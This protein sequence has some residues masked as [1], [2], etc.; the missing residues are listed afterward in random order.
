MVPNTFSL[1]P[2][3]SKDDIGDALDL[4]AIRESKGLT[5]KDIFEMTRISVVNLEAIENNALH[6]L[7]APVYTKTFIKTYAKALGVDSK[8]ILE[9]YAKHLGTLN[10][11]LPEEPTKKTA[12]KINIPL[13]ASI[14]SITALIFC[15]LVF[16]SFALRDKTEMEVRAPAHQNDPAKLPDNARQ[17]DGTNQKAPTAES[18]QAVQKPETAPLVSQQ[19]GMRLT[20][21]PMQLSVPTPAA[22]IANEKHRQSG[23]SPLQYRLSITA[24]ELTWIKIVSDHNPPYEILLKPGEKLDRSAAERFLLDIG[25]AGGIDAEFQGNSMGNLGKS[26][27]VVHLKLP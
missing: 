16:L 26:G 23:A 9:R 1:L 2:D 12:P 15:S 25:N 11:S 8:N 22:M 10:T 27:E 3:D 4:K 21:T 6:L 14:W 18:S 7:P 13:R 24:K 20:T 19:E 17:P 5:L